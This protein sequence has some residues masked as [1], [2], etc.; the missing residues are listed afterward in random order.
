MISDQLSA[1]KVFIAFNFHDRHKS[2]QVDYFNFHLVLFCNNQQ[3]D[4]IS[5]KLPLWHFFYNTWCQL[6]SQCSQFLANLVDFFV[7]MTQIVFMFP[8]IIHSD[9][10]VA[11]IVRLINA[12]SKLIELILSYDDPSCRH[13]DR[14]IA[15]AMTLM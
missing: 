3:R 2:V 13:W 6:V 1:T 7:I 10:S 12:S 5:A 14:I 8:V 9:F 11:R 15:S 4:S